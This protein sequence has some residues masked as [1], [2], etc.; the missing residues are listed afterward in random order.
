VSTAT[1]EGET[2]VAA[3][4]FERPIGYVASEM[5][6]RSVEAVIELLAAAG[7]AAVDWT[8]EHY[9]PLE[10]PPRRLEEIVKR[11]RAAGLA[12]PQLM[13]HQDHV[14]LDQGLWSGVCAGRSAPCWP[15]HTQ[16]SA[17]SGC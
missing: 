11:S 4:T 1:A 16:E 5:G 12:T 3:A 2:R 17:R 8:M 10:E 15:A 6:G 9:D 14:A 13:V 7:Y